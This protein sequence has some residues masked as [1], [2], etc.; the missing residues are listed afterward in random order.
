MICE[1]DQWLHYNAKN[2]HYNLVPDSIGGKRDEEKTYKGKKS[3]VVLTSSPDGPSPADIARRLLFGLLCAASPTSLDEDAPPLAS[4]WGRTTSHSFCES[5]NLIRLTLA[6]IFPVISIG[7][8]SRSTTKKVS[9][10][11]G[12]R[13]QTHAAGDKDMGLGRGM[14]GG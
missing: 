9:P 4:V 5:A 3:N 7:H 10:A 13:R 6:G 1:H 8:G 11:M 2:K 12:V 14:C